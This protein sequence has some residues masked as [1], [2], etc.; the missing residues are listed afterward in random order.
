MKIK[1]LF[2][3]TRNKTNKQL[4]YGLRVRELKK[5]G[6]TPEELANATILKPKKFIK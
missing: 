3:V 2:S 1:N 5:L 4:N 6:L